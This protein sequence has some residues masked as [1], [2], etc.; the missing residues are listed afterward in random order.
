MSKYKVAV[1]GVTGAV[2]QEMLRILETQAFP[3][4]E[5]VPLAS[6]RSVGKRVTFSGESIPVQIL[7]ENAFRGCDFALFSPGATV[8]KQFAPCAAE[9]GAWV[10]DNTSAFRMD[11]DVPLVVPEVNAHALTHVPRRI[12]ANPNCSTIQLVVALHPIHRAAGLTRVVVSTFQAVSGAGQKALVELDVQLASWSAGR[13]EPSPTVFPHP[14]AFNCIPQIGAFDASG[15]SVEEQKVMN[16]TRRILGLPQLR[17]SATTVRVPVRTG[18]SEAVN[19]ELERPLRRADA[20]ALLK[21][22]P[23][24]EVIDDPE[25]GCYPLARHAAGK[26]AVFVGRIREDRSVPHGLELWIVADNL[27]KGA[28][29]NAVQIAWALHQRH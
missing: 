1:V 20:I 27:R 11:T 28:A 24:I 7:D 21:Q 29:L 15:Y 8:S 10:V 6:A 4:R 25:K 16:E 9:A 26:D 18:H 2:G 12:I 13:D 5:L 14:I 22:S 3:V 17:I 19:V 23:G